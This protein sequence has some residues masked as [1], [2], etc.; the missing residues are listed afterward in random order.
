MKK[1]IAKQDSAPVVAKKITPVKSKTTKVKTPV[2]TKSSKVTKADLLKKPAFVKEAKNM[3][4]GQ[5]ALAKKY[6]VS[7][8]TIR[9]C[10]IELKVL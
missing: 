9:R 8:S 3:K 7:V 10:R 6:G 1:E 5:S 2:K 4:N